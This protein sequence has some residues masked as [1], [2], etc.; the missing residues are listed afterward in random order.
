M[1]D[2]GD[3]ESRAVHEIP[4]A[5]LGLLHRRRRQPADHRRQDQ[6]EGGV[7][8]ARDHGAFGD[9]ASDGTELPADLIVYATGYGSMNGWAADLIA[10]EVADKVGKVWGLGSDTHQRPRPLGRR[11]AQHVEADAAGGAVVPWRQP[12]PV[13]ALFAVSGAAAQGAHGGHPD[14]GLRAAGGASPRVTGCGTPE[15]VIAIGSGVHLSLL[16]IGGGTGLAKTAS[17]CGAAGRVAFEQ[18]RG[19]VWSMGLSRIQLDDIL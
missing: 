12:A 15:Q 17:V 7:R 8:R 2:W 18:A 16:T 14:A 4:A 11:T 13:A 10:Q 3:D 1:L 6:A 5:R 9:P 19:P